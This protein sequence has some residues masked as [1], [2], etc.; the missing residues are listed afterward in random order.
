VLVFVLIFFS[1]PFVGDRAVMN[2][3]IC[4]IILAREVLFDISSM[5]DRVI[6]ILSCFCLATEFYVMGL[7]SVL[8]VFV[9]DYDEQCFFLTPLV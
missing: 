9:K 4:F 1:H 3:M 7:P 2:I 6:V 5:K 8:V